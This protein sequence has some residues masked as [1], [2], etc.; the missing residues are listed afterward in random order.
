M[1]DQEVY[2]FGTSPFKLRLILKEICAGGGGCVEEGVLCHTLKGG[3]WPHS[4]RRG[5]LAIPLE[6]VVPDYLPW[7]M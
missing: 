5:D 6:E 1:L 2:G 3:T 4:K 7:R